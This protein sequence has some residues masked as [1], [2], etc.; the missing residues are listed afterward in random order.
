VQEFNFFAFRGY[1]CVS[2]SKVTPQLYLFLLVLDS[3]CKCSKLWNTGTATISIISPCMPETWLDDGNHLF[4]YGECA[5][6][7]NSI[8]FQISDIRDPEELTDWWTTLLR[9]DPWMHRVSDNSTLTARVG[10]WSPRPSATHSLPDGYSSTLI[11]EATR[12]YFF[13]SRR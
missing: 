7:F 13:G 3:C 10:F 6:N 12:N 2:H 5:S 9:Q 4:G 1:R 11:S 8:C